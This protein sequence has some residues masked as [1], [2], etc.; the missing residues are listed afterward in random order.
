MLRMGIGQL[1]QSGLDEEAVRTLTVTNP[2]QL[3]GIDTVSD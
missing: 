1:L 2:R 3:L